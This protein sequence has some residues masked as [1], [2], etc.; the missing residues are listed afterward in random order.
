MLISHLFIADD[1]L[2]FCNHDENNLSFLGC[3]LLL[4]KAMFGLRVSLS[5]TVLIPIGEV[6]EIHH[7]AL[8]FGCGPE[9]LPSRGQQDWMPGQ[10]VGNGPSP[11]WSWSRNSGTG[12]SPGWTD[13]RILG[14][15]PGT[16]YPVSFFLVIFI[17]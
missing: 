11:G 16:G 3:I 4:S 17:F 9:H 8:F 15:G 14:P 2:Y 5:K 1:A 10:I 12:P 6:L 13:S 7:L